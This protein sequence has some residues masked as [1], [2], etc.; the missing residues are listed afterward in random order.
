MSK[1]E[2][3]RRSFLKGTA[4]AGASLAAASM[5]PRISMAEGEGTEFKWETGVTSIGDWQLWDP[6][7]G[8]LNL[9]GRGLHCEV[10]RQGPITLND[11]MKD[12]KEMLLDGRVVSNNDPMLRWYTDNV[13]LSKEARHADKAN[14]MPTKRKRDLK[15]DGFM[16]W[17]FAHTLAM[18]AREP[19]YSDDRFDITHIRL[20]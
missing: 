9:E 16:A 20:D 6:A 10:V 13:R 5:L 11:P 18:R 15:I 1:K 3:S 4:A 17:L 12:L 7:T 2:I 19:E 8:E 14:W